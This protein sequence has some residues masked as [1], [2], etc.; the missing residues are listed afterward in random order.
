MKQQLR[1]ASLNIANYDDHA[2]WMQRRSLIIDELARL[3]P[4]IIAL[5]EVRYNSEHES[6]AE[7]HLNAAE[8]IF[9]GLQQRGLYLNASITTER[10]MHYRALADTPFWEGLSV[11]ASIPVI[12]SGKRRFAHLH[13]SFDNNRRILQYLL[14]NWA[15]REIC[16]LHTHYTFDML[17]LEHNIAETL[18][19]Y[20]R[21]AALPVVLM[22]DMNVTPDAPEFRLLKDK[23][24]SDVWNHLHPGL[25]GSTYPTINPIQRI[26]YIW[27]N[28][29]ALTMVKDIA[30]WADKPDAEGLYCSDHIGL[31]ITL[32]R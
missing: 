24:F 6:T 11:I 19:V 8:Q 17:G 2:H 16:L 30:L 14:L 22:G 15:D 1:I 18:M 5:Q 28:P 29:A 13:N 21:V 9:V 3:Q 7:T 20:R 4:D 32:Q 27:A 23:H 26:D 31:V 12:E 25:P 10:G